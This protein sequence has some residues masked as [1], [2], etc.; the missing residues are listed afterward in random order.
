M[1][2]KNCLISG[3]NMAITTVTNYSDATMKGFSHKKK[4]ARLMKAGHNDF[5]K[6]GFC[7]DTNNAIENHNHNCN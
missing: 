2:L 7:E 1:V 4:G 3:M 6:L 5:I